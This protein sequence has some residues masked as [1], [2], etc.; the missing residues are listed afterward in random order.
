M[1]VQRLT[2]IAAL[3]GSRIPQI[4]GT[5]LLDINLSKC[6]QTKCFLLLFSCLIHGVLYFKGTNERGKE[7]LTLTQKAVNI[8]ELLKVITRKVLFMQVIYYY[9]QTCVSAYDKLT[10]IVS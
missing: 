5:T 3:K 1:F 6:C 9:L 2:A 7:K 10:E 8:S 4:E